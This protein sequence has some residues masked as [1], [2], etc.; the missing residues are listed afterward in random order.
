MRVDRRRRHRMAHGEAPPG[1]SELPG[2]GAVLLL[3]APTLAPYFLTGKG[4]QKPAPRRDTARVWS[5][6]DHTSD[7]RVRPPRHSLSGALG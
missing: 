6:A 3:M 4:P 7:M 2:A 5:S 1:L